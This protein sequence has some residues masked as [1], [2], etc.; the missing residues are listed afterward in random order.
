MSA[1][2]VTLLGLVESAHCN[3]DTLTALAA[4]HGTVWMVRFVPV[5]RGALV[6]LATPEEAR[7]A[8]QALQGHVL[9]DGTMLRAEQGDRSVTPDEVERYSLA[10]PKQLIQLVS[11]PS[12]PPEWWD[13]WHE[14]EEGPKSPPE[15]LVDREADQ[16]ELRLVGPNL[17]EAIAVLQRQQ[18]GDRDGDESGAVVRPPLITIQAPHGSVVPEGFALR[19][20]A[21]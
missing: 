16:H 11:P 14:H 17:F 10:A 12:S 3:V 21:K 7:A 8:A 9:P 6:V 13:G 4:A 5:L 15:L 20:T 1:N 18:I 19:D 2:V